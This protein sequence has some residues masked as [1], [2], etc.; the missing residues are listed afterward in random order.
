MWSP[1]GPHLLDWIRQVPVIV[2]LNYMYNM[3]SE[4]LEV[5]QGDHHVRGCSYKVPLFYVF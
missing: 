5:D 3:A 1:L 4:F 2:R